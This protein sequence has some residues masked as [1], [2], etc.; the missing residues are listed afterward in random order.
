MTAHHEAEAARTAVEWERF[1]TARDRRYR[2]N[3][4]LAVSSLSRLTWLVA[5]IIIFI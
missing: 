2:S 3:A 4:S 5:C 1:R